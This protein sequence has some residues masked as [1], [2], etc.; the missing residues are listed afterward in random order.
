VAA[1]MASGGRWMIRTGRSSRLRPESA[2]GRPRKA[3]LEGLVGRFAA[4]SFDHVRRLLRA[5]G[6]R[7]NEHPR[8]WPPRKGSPREQAR[9]AAPLDGRV[10]RVVPAAC[11]QCPGALAVAA[12]EAD[13]TGGQGT[14]TTS[15]TPLPDL[16][17]F[18]PHGLRSLGKN[19]IRRVGGFFFFLT[20]SRT[21][22]ISGK[23]DLWAK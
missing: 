12:P 15:P 13:A 1:S 14:S 16:P 5:P 19:G 10:G 23:F 18:C 4:G 2:P 7:D 21:P 11:P 3:P 8:C 6:P 17:G 9:V 22:L 20:R